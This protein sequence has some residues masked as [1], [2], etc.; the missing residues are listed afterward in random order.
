MSLFHVMTPE[1]KQFGRF[2][3]II[4]ISIGSTTEDIFKD[5]VCKGSA[6]GMDLSA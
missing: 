3:N 2:D 5:L 1:S 6:A 4:Y